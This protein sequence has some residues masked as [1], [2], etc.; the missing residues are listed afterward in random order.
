M[1]TRWE[2]QRSIGPAGVGPR[3]PRGTLNMTPIST[4]RMP[5]LRRVDERLRTLDV[6]EV[7][8]CAEA[9]MLGV[10]VADRVVARRAPG[11]L[12]VE[13]TPP[14]CFDVLPRVWSP[15][16]PARATPGRAPSARPSRGSGRGTGGGGLRARAGHREGARSAP[17][18]GCTRWPAERRDQRGSRPAPR[19]AH[20]PGREGRAGGSSLSTIAPLHHRSR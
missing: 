13:A 10:E 6:D 9:A 7:P 1:H 5:R 11:E 14:R 15:R 3:T 19:R 16:A 2:C 4:G 20:N 8:I 17:V 18:R 12:R